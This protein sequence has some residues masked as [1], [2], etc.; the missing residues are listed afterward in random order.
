MAQAGSIMLISNVVF[1]SIIK[2][3]RVLLDIHGCY[4]ASALR[5]C[6]IAK[7]KLLLDGTVPRAKRC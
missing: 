3:K 7:D 6:L 4:N 1:L 2:F 5:L